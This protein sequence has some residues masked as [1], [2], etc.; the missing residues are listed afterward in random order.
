MLFA[1]YSDRLDPGKGWYVLNE[2]L[3]VSAFRKYKENSFF[4][5]FPDE[6]QKIP[7]CELNNGSGNPLDPTLLGVKY[8]KCDV[9][10]ASTL[11]LCG[12]LIRQRELKDQSY[13][14]SDAFKR[15]GQVINNHCA[16]TGLP[17]KG[18]NFE[19]LS[20]KNEL[21]KAKD[22]IRELQDF[23]THDETVKSFD[24]TDNKLKKSARGK[25]TKL[26]KKSAGGILR[27]MEDVCSRHKASVASVLGHLCTNDPAKAPSEARDIISEIV[28]AV[29]EKKG[30]KRGLEAIVPDVLQQ[31]L[32]QFRVPD[33]VLLYFKLEARIPDEGWQTM[34]NLT[35]LGRTGVSTQNLAIIVVITIIDIVV[36]LGGE[37]EGLDF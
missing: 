9:L 4:R 25:K 21:G 3:H 29:T 8:K 7:F 6:V 1:V 14:R 10:V 13:L 26:T 23:L 5:L 24:N 36:Y 27:S 18:A 28:S 32:H 12:G 19:D 37:G 34:I 17:R 20:A 22:T 2:E 11:G 35:K 33:W 16:I 15:I 31:Y 30:V